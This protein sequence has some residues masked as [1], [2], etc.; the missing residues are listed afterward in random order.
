MPL[1]ITLET[2][3]VDTA[4]DYYAVFRRP[5]GA[6]WKPGTGTI[7][8]YTSTRSDFA[9][10]ATHAGN[11]V[12]SISIH[13]PVG[14]WVWSWFKASAPGSQLNTDARQAIGGAYYNGVN[15]ADPPEVLATIAGV[16]SQLVFTS[17]TGP[18]ADDSLLDYNVRLSHPT[19]G[20]DG[21]FVSSVRRIVAHDYDAGVH[22]Y[23]IES[24]AAFTIAAGVVLEFYPPGGPEL[25]DI[26]AEIVA[27]QVV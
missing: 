3:P 27:P 8:P 19:A 2:H 7:V 4:A 18:E 16:T 17:A 11:G 5:T 1:E 21:G 13:L 10:L 26:V 24:A 22:T 9:V 23:T 20:E 15:A 25:S 6:A 14:P 12:H